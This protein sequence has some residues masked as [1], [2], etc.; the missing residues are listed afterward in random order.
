M[1]NNRLSYSLDLWY[2]QFLSLS[3][4]ETVDTCMSYNKCMYFDMLLFN[5]WKV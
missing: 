2:L 3:I 5:F 4:P 1:G